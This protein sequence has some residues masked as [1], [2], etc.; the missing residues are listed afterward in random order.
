MSACLLMDRQVLERVIR[1]YF[2]FF[3]YVSVS[4]GFFLLSVSCCEIANDLIIITSAGLLFYYIYLF[5]NRDILF[6][7][8]MNGFSFYSG[9]VSHIKILR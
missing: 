3:F 1:K 6:D 8:I 2:F 5:C 4:E 9:N 7:C